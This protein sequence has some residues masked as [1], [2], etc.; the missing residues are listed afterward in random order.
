MPEEKEQF[1]FNMQADFK[2]SKTKL[3]LQQEI[4][5]VSIHMANHSFVPTMRMTFFISTKYRNMLLMPYTV[6]LRIIEKNMAEDERT[7]MEQEWLSYGQH[8][9]DIKRESGKENR[10]DIIK[11]THEFIAKDVFAAI[12]TLVGGLY[13]NTTVKN[14]IQ[15]LWN[16]TNHGKTNLEINDLDNKET[17]DQI[18]VPNNKFFKN[19]SYLSQEYGMFIVPPVMYSDGNTVYIKSLNNATKEK[20]LELYVDTPENEQRKLKVDKG[21][22]YIGKPPT[23]QN[24]FN[25][26]SS[27][28][29][30]K[31]V[32]TKK[33]QSELYESDEIDVIELIKSLRFVDSTDVFEEF[34]DKIVIPKTHIYVDH[35]NL[36]SLKESIASI[37]MNTVKPLD[38]QISHPFRFS[39]WYIGRKVILKYNHLEYKMGTEITFFVSELDFVISR[40]ASKRVQGNIYAKLNCVSTKNAFIGG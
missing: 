3:T 34:L 31:I 36:Y 35:S 11:V 16:S 25:S 7:V 13:E 6:I 21:Q 19:L 33:S 10:P 28:I 20:A 23:I 14:I 2:F 39:H 9:N 40:T 8:A 27:I 17:Y 1:A 26:I 29:P 15:Q 37:V 22:Y 12:N 18:W 5:S 24:S 4:E 32:V 30:K 38:I